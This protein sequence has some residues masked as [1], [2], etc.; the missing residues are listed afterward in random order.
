MV[1][2]DMVFVAVEVSNRTFVSYVCKKSKSCVCLEINTSASQDS[3]KKVISKAVSNNANT[4]ARVG[5]YCSMMWNF[6][7]NH[8]HSS[9]PNLTS[10]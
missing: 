3:T 2:V 4:M 5:K 10:S 1:V 6:E 7:Q 9:I 8:V